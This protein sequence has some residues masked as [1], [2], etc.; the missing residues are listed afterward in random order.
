MVCPNILFYFEKLHHRGAVTHKIH[1]S[2][3]LESGV[4]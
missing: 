4:T 3:I 1:L 2:V